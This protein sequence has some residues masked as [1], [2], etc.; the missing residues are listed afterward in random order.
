MIYDL[1]S[2]SG[3]LTNNRISMLAFL[4]AI[5]KN[6]NLVMVTEKRKKRSDDAVHAA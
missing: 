1:L 4:A 5:E 3:T 2:E 6:K